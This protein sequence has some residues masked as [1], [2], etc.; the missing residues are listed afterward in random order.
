MSNHF[1]SDSSRIG[2]QGTPLE[3]VPLSHHQ[4]PEQQLSPA[5]KELAKRFKVT[6]EIIAFLKDGTLMNLSGMKRDEIITVEKK[7]GV[8]H[9]PSL[10][11]ADVICK[12]SRN[13]LILTY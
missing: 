12:V 5:L 8:Q 2:L 10:L 7:Y 13:K 9:Q 11:P 4:H 3:I 6:T 1:V